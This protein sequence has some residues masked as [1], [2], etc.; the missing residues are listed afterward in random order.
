MR[1]YSCDNPNALDR[2]DNQFKSIQGVCEVV[3]RELCKEGIGTSVQNAAVI[4]N[5]EEDQLLL[6]TIVLFC[7]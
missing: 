2:R 1:S 3:F 6:K 4:M 7:F 5:E